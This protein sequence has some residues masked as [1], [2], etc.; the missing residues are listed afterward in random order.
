LQPL[1]AGE[2]GGADTP[3]RAA[4]V[5]FVALGQEQVGEEPAVGQLLA[6][7]GVGGVDEP[8]SRGRRTRYWAQ[9]VLAVRYSLYEITPDSTQ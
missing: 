4:A 2:P 5:P 8:D 6:F 7:G 3:F 9:S 1:V